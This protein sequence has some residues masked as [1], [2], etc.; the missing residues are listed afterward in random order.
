MAHYA[1]LDENNNVVSVHAVDD[2]RETVN[3]VT[4]E[5]NGIA[6]L[7]R[8]HGWDN[9]KKTSYHTRAGK[10]RN[11]DGSIADDQ[12]KM[13]RYNYAGV[14]ST[15]DEAADAFIPP[16]PTDDEGN[17]LQ[18]W[19]LDTNTYTWRAPIDRPSSQTNGVEDLYHWNET[20]QSWDKEV[21]YRAP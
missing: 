14:G 10:Y 5:A 13:L 9:F 8:V 17:I 16:K 6:H 11:H 20:T 3:G 2:A 18:S 12:S 7:K 1:R 21:I 4:S 15:Y 19:V